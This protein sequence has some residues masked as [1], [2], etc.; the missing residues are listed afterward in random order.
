MSDEKV[1]T[2]KEAYLA[3]YSFLVGYYELTKADDV[4]SMLGGLSLMADGEPLD[5][6]FLDDWHKAVEKARNGHVDAYMRLTKPDPSEG[7]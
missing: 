3:M 6:A 7:E 5:P 2:S 1:L 4:G